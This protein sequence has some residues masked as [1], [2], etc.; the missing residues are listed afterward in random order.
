MESD[1][2]QTMEFDTGQTKRLS[3]PCHFLVKKMSTPSGRRIV[4]VIA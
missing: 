3:G 4:V 2:G 1:T